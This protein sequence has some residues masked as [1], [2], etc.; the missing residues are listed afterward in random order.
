MLRRSIPVFALTILT[1]LAAAGCGGSQPKAEPVAESEGPAAA[2]DTPAPQPKVK[3]A[4]LDAYKEAVSAYKAGRLSDAEGS[5][6]E[7]EDEDAKFSRA[8]FNLGVLA[9]MQGQTDKAREYYKKVIEHDSHDGDGFVNLAA[10]AAAEGRTGEAEAGYQQAIQVEPLNGYA[11]L[12]LAMASKNRKDFADAVKRVRT[13]LKE[14]S[15]N[16]D[17]YVVLAWTYYD[18]G[19]LELAKLVCFQALT[20]SD[21]T[22]AV[23][24]LLGLVHMK[25]ADVTKAMASFQKAVEADPKYVPALMN[26]GALAFSYKDYE[27]SYRS[28]DQAS[29]VQPKDPTILS[30]KGVAARGMGNLEEA[31]KLYREVLAA[32]ERQPSVWFN[33]G[34]LQQEFQQKLP[35]AQK[36]FENVLKFEQSN[37]ALRKDASDR[38]QQVQIQIQNLKEAEAMMREAAE[39]EKKAAAEAAKA[40]PPA[41]PSAPASE[42]PT[43]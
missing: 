2:G 25:M 23:H 38:I 11:H 33:L 43:P 26:V 24:N 12:N 22:P 15:Q 5:L 42:Q 4:A 28:F 17:A 20:I 41:A 39:Q 18:M 30:A 6:K 31:E 8:T 14:D 19:R 36:S 27:T 40:G 35:D 37:G 29:K 3:R 32:D 34:I 13:A 7:A 9:E 21:K 10:L 16:I 1:G